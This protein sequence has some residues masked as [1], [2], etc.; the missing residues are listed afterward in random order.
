MVRERP[1][2]SLGSMLAIGALLGLLMSLS[3]RR[4][5]YDPRLQ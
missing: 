5:H 4:S 3:M 2:S 1:V